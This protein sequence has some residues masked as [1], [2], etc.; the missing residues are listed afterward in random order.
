M[1]YVEKMCMQTG[2]FLETKLYMTRLCVSVT[3][4]VS[5]HM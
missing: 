5:T 2:V 4:V 3:V 1:V